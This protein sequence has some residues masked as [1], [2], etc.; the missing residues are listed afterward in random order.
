MQYLVINNSRC[1][2]SLPAPLSQYTI[3]Y[4]TAT[5]T[6]TSAAIKPNYILPCTSVR[7]DT[8]LPRIKWYRLYVLYRVRLVSYRLQREE[9]IA[10]SDPTATII[11]T[12]YHYSGTYAGKRKKKRTAMKRSE[13]RGCAATAT[14]CL[15]WH[16][17]MDVCI[18]V[19]FR[20]F[21]NKLRN[22][23]QNFLSSV[24]RQKS[25]KMEF[26]EQLFPCFVS[27]YYYSA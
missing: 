5:A 19:C 18:V 6:S 4:A 25:Y 11:I 9:K 16:L 21:G 7:V 3:F 14:F 26:A 8:L 15:W 22:L 17:A 13:G 12:F 10:S 27:V 20:V 1:P 24:Q 2:K 23:R